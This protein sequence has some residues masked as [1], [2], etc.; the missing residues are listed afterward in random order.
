MYPAACRF[1]DGVFGF[2]PV[3]RVRAHRFFVERYWGSTAA[4]VALRNGT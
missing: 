1:R 2:T 3:F 4:V